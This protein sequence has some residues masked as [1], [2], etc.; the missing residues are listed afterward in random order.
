MA[1]IFATKWHPIEDT[2]EEVIDF[3]KIMPEDGSKL[4]LGKLFPHRNWCYFE[5][6]MEVKSIE[7][8]TVKSGVFSA[9]LTNM[10]A[11]VPRFRWKGTP[12][13]VHF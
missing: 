11:W 7:D 2:I 3:F 12:P 9:F 4:Y 10:S 13:T 6:N 8:Q 1:H 5:Q